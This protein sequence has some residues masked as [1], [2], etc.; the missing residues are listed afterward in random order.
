VGLAT[1]YRAQGRDAEARTVLSG[2]VT[3]L[4]QP[5]ADAFWTVVHAFNLLGDRDAAREWSMKARAR[6]PRDSRF[7]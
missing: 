3:A 5:D 2:V 4:P 1:L 6:F 7:K